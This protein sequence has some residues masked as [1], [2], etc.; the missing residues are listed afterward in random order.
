[1]RNKTFL[2][3][4]NRKLKHLASIWNDILW[5]LTTFQLIQHIHT[6][7]IFNFC[8]GC[9]IELKFCK[10]PRNSFSNRCWNFFKSLSIS[11]QNSFVYWPNFQWRFW[12]PCLQNCSPGSSLLNYYAFN[13]KKMTGEMYS[14]KKFMRRTCKTICTCSCLQIDCTA[15]QDFAPHTTAQ[16]C[17]FNN[18]SLI[19]I[20]FL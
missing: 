12:C 3:F 20:D 6:I 19:R 15:L 8:I 4:Q 1:M 13:L 11:K 16:W 9:L 10:I 17:V 5:N 18:S 14:P 7:V 2:V